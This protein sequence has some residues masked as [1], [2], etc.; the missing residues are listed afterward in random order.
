MGAAG[1][2]TLGCGEW[3]FRNRSIPEYF[4]IATGLGFRHL[5]FGIGGGWAGRLPDVPTPADVAAFRALAERHGVTT[6]YCCLE[7]DFTRPDAAEHDA[8][9][10][11]VLAQL[12]VAADCG[13]EVVRLFAGFTPAEEMTEAIWGRLLDALGTCAAAAGRLGMRIAIETHGAITHLPSGAAVHRHTVSTRRDWLARLVREMPAEVAFNWDPGNLKAADPS[14]ERYAADLLAGRIAYVHMKDWRRAGDG[15][16]DADGWVACAPGDDAIDYARLFPVAGFGG[17]YLIEYEPLE[18][19]VDGLTRQPSRTSAGPCR[20]RRSTATACCEP[21][22]GGTGMY[23]CPWAV[24]TACP[25]ARLLARATRRLRIH[26][27]DGR[28]RGTGRL[29]IS[30]RVTP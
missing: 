21:S 29:P 10:R 11:T 2:V 1:S 27:R 24:F 19:T 12:P 5:E 17:V 15:G 28:T 16:E 9:V 4:E 13:A 3:G 18:D 30:G 25:R 8:Q 26:S 14:D 20:R 7:T 6:R 23:P 22:S